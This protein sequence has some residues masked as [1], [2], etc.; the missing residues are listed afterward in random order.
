MMAAAL[1][2]GTGAALAQTQGFMTRDQ[3]IH[4]TAYWTGERFADGRPKVSDELLDRLKN[5]TH[6]EAWAT[7]RS[8]GFYSQYEDGWQSLFPEK[9]QVGRVLTSGWMPGRP[10][11]GKIIETDG[12]AAGRKNDTNAWPV[13]MLQKRDVYVSDHF[14]LKVGGASI[15]DNVGNAIYAKTGNGIVYDGT[16]RDINGLRKLPD[17][18]SFWR[19][20]D[21]SYHYGMTR[22]GANYN[23]TMVSINAPIR[24]GKVTVMP[25]DVTL[26]RDGGVLFIPP[27]LVERV[28]R[29]SERT[30]LR[31]Q[32]GQLRLREGKYTA[33]QI[34]GGWAPEIEADYDQW[35]KANVNRLGI[36]AS[37]VQ[38]IITERANRPAGGRGGRGGAPGAAGPGGP[39][40][41]R[42]APQQAQ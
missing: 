6:E 12:A 36:P 3:V 24:I 4:N 2:A 39:G 19:S 14:G 33:G 27:Q 38:A 7:L 16:V 29:E 10:D 18:V 40:A 34:D 37:A 32:F 22:T 5:V 13:D 11:I 28:V 35:L 41:G 31:D 26:G 20:Y 8:A 17:F 15:G 21:P 30:Q 42:G 23:S 25:G 1:L 9:V